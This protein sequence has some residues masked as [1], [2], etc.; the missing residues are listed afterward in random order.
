MANYSERK[1]EILRG[2]KNGKTPEEL[3]ITSELEKD[4]YERHKE[5][6]DELTAKGVNVVWA[7]VTD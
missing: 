3:N 7:P 1:W 2:I 5:I 6:Y 4:F